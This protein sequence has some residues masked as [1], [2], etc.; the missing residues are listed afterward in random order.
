M[1]VSQVS[2]FMQSKPGHLARVLK[3]F[4]SEHINVRGYSVSDTGECG[5]ARFVL[6]K[7]NEAQEALHKNGA[8]F[9]VT[10][11]ICLKLEDKPGE[12]ARIASVLAECGINIKYSYSMISTYIVLATDNVEDARRI[13]DS[14]PVT[15]VSQSDL[16]D[17]NFN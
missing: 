16:S 11:V 13:L 6:D 2:V 1:T 12:L 8:A 17:M 4:E 3:S 14:E 7:P 5:I 9:A 15:I 10:Q